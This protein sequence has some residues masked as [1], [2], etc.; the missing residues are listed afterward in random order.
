VRLERELGIGGMRPVHSGVAALL[1]LLALTVSACLAASPA[2]TGTQPTVS[3]DR[4]V[5]HVKSGRQGGYRI[6]LGIVSVPP[7]F[8]PQ[9]VST[10]GR[11]WPFWSKAGLAI[12]GGTRPVAVMV[13]KSWRKRAAIEW[14]SSGPVS[15]LRIAP[16]RALPPSVWNA[17]AGGFHIRTRSA[18]VPLIFRVE[19][20]Q[21]TV[22]FGLGRRCG[23]P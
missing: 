1:G 17:Y 2:S 16:C 10:Q 21:T 4:I 18:C 12:R 22:R 8:R 11:P 15:A 6:V 7:A 23:A 3:C 20:R 13:P 5:L 14:G 19:R 9:V